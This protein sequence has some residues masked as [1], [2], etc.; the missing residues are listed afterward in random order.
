MAAIGT[1]RQNGILQTF[2]DIFKTLHLLL[3]ALL[4]VVPS[5]AVGRAEDC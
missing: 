3:V 5:S 1:L 4:I 2:E